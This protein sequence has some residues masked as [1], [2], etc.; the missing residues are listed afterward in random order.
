[1]VNFAFF[2]RIA[3]PASLTIA[4]FMSLHNISEY[5]DKVFIIEYGAV[6]KNFIRAIQNEKVASERFP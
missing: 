5:D 4:N 3:L 1:M 2:H 6:F